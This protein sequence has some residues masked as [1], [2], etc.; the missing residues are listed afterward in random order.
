MYLKVK[1]LFK[2][3]LSSVLDIKTIDPVISC[4]SCLNS[5]VSILIQN[6]VEFELRS[7][8]RSE[9]FEDS[10][11]GVNY[12]CH[13]WNKFCCNAVPSGFHFH[14][15]VFLVSIKVFD[16]ILDSSSGFEYFY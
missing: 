13:Q 6:A 8:W 5:Y 9:C 10:L 2:P 11:S 12:Y 15:F 16:R 3:L 7:N 1:V 14:S 4:T